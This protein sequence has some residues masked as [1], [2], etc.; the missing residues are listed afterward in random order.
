MPSLHD[1]RVV[2]VAAFG[3]FMHTKLVGDV[4]VFDVF[5]HT[6]FVGDVVVVADAL[7]DAFALQTS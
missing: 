4:V 2:D 7:A 1:K 6:K 5:M 3:V